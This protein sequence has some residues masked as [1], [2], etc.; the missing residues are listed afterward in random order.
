MELRKYQEYAIRTLLEEKNKDKLIARLALGISGESGEIAEKV[1]KYLR[2][3]YSK[4]VLKEILKKEIGDVLW[5]CSVL[6]NTLGLS[7][8]NIA[9]ENL[10]K[11][12]ERQ[13]KGKIKGNGDNR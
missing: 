12:A 3:D 6:A 9:V 4:S 13:E 10:N 1:K 11:L 2:G 7:L 5:Y 8:N